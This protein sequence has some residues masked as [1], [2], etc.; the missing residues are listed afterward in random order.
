MEN[1]GKI[2]VFDWTESDYGGSTFLTVFHLRSSP[3]KNAHVTTV[4]SARHA[5]SDERVARRAQEFAFYYSFERP[6]RTK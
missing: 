6:T 5:R 4:L 3:A 2:D 1:C